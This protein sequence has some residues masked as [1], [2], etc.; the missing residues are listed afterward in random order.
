MGRCSELEGCEWCREAVFRYLRPIVQGAHERSSS[1]AISCVRQ[2]NLQHDGLTG[3]RLHKDLHATT[4]EGRRLLSDVVIRK[5]APICL[6][7]SGVLGLARSFQVVNLHLDIID[8]S[9]DSTLMVFL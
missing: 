1:D 4:D 5:D 9:E 8:V 6:H 7:S 2:L 3:Q